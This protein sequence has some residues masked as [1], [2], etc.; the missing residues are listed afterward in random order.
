MQKLQINL[1]KI[2]KELYPENYKTMKKVIE[3][4]VKKKICHV[5]GLEELILLK[6][7]HCLLVVLLMQCHLLIQCNLYQDSN[8][9]F[10]L[11]LNFILFLLMYNWFTVL[12]QF[13]LYSIVTQSYIN[14]HS[15]FHIIFHQVLFKKIGYSSLCYI[16]GPHFLSILYVMAIF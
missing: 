14:I 4:N 16:L 12:C 5:H 10:F 7:Q 3:V 8:A 9:F 13:L 11:F 2:V 15:F 6:C 1:A